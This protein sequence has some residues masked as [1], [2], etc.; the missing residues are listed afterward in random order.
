MRVVRSCLFGLLAGV[1][2]LPGLASVVQGDE[3]MWVFNNLPRKQLKEKYGFEPT[4][5]WIEHVMKSSV[6]F[7]SGGS[8]SFVSSNGLVLTNHHVGADTLHKVSTAEHDYYKEG[9]LA[10]TPADEPKAPDL[11]LNVLQSI[12]DVTA[13][14]NAAVKPEMNPGEAFLARRAVIAT[15]EKESL[16]KTG[17]RSDVVTLY[18]GGQYH[19][20]R[21][22]KYTDIRLVWAPEFDI[23]FFGGDPDNFEYPRYDLD[24]C[25]FRAYENDQPAKIEHFLQWNPQGAGADELVFVSGHPG[26]T[27][28][29]NTMDALKF[30]RDVRA[31]YVLTMLRRMEIMLQQYSQDG[32]EQARI[33]KEDLF[34]VQNSRKAYLG[35]LGGLQDPG[36]MARKATA[37][38]TLRDKVNADPKM[39]QA[40]GGAWDKIAA[41]KK[42]HQENL[43][44]SALLEQGRGFGGTLFPIARTRVG[45]A[46]ENA[47]PNTAR[48][49]GSSDAGRS[50]LELQLYST[51]PIYPDLELAKLTDSLGYLA[52]QL[53]ADDPLV[54]QVLA[55][56][57][58][59][60]RAAELLA[61]TK[62]QDVAERKKL[63]AGGVGAIDA[64][65]DTLI[66]LA[67]LVDP[68]ARAVREVMEKQVTE[69][70]RQA[71]A[72][73]SKALFEIE[74]PS[75]YPDATFTLR[76]SYGTVK[77]YEENGKQ[78]DPIT[79]MGGAFEHANR[80]ANKA[81]WELPKSW[82][83][84]RSQIGAETAF[85][86]VSTCDII[87]GNSGSP[88]IN[89]KGELV[90][91]IFDGNIQ[92]LVGDFIYDETQNRAV[93]V[94][95][96]AISEAL[97]KIYNAGALADQ[98]GK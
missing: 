12:E 83:D 64:S 60:A 59:A 22:K 28:R 79:R 17:L 98:L 96:A 54:K 50:S 76:L 36:I 46:P 89:R 5:A 69:V 77:G 31:P 87:G 74:G 53:G 34:G 58:P 2:A 94:S 19:L 32:E 11:E 3:G 91:L 42:I 47:K 62:L 68:A 78:I 86:F 39:K 23:A 75:R 43:V 30:Q 85:N 40:Y 16:D 6:R 33:A 38:K 92:S 95:S 52:E 97:R 73:I 82:H 44:R 84:K 63:A 61:G 7:N 15:I 25:L 56:K 24:A 35:Q 1:C 26:R 71:Y 41:A 55:G 13:R 93:S 81:P 14:V 8:G 21:Y 18:Q 57:G 67:K 70:E 27:D 45:L 10:K 9:F 65:T 48:L 37:E 51:A 29:L 88:V 20:Y 66:Q 49:P 72:Q 4:E 80:H 90:G